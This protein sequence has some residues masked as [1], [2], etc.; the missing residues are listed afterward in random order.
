MNTN[1]FMNYFEVHS[2][3]TSFVPDLKMYPIPDHILNVMNKFWEENNDKIHNKF[4]NALEYGF[5]NQVIACEKITHAFIETINDLTMLFY[6]E[7]ETLITKGV[8][9]QH[10]INYIIHQLYHVVQRGVSDQKRRSGLNITAYTY[11]IE[12]YYEKRVE[13]VIYRIELDIID[14]KNK[15]REFKDVV[16][17]Y[18]K[19]FVD[20]CIRLHQLVHNPEQEVFASSLSCANYD[21]DRLMKH[22][23]Y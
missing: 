23:E 2:N 1:I 22:N 17:L 20:T 6:N 3:P 14:F 8:S 4:K 18:D 7:D 19:N 16:A 11:P 5:N 10:I 13:C 21:I 12:V 9:T 15:T